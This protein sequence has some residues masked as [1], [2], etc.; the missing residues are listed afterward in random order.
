ML[1]VILLLL[2]VDTKLIGNVDRTLIFIIDHIYLLY[3]ILINFNILG[4][5]KIEFYSCIRTFK[6]TLVLE[7]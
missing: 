2:T 7:Y 5:R 1:V 3:R 4:L 6:D